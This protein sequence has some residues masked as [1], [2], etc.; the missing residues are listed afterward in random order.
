M[1]KHKDVL[2]YVGSVIDAM[3]YSPVIGGTSVKDTLK[4]AAQSILELDRLFDEMPKVIYC[5]ECK[6]LHTEDLLVFVNDWHEWQKKVTECR[7]VK[8]AA[9]VSAP[10]E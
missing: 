3:D 8:D 7:R 5:E 10:A 6:A 4:I 1:Q 2:A 9:E